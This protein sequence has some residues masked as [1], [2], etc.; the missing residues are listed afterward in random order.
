MDLNR[1]TQKAQQAIFA[2]GQ[3][4]SG[5]NHQLVGTKHL[6]AAL[7]DQEQGITGRFLQQAG[8]DTAAL[9]RDLQGLI[10]QIPQV[11]GYKGTMQ[12]DSTLA[13]VL[14][15]ERRPSSSRTIMSV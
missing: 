6:L 15:A 10:D 1:F 2:A 8:V 7:I 9:R 11:T 12:V 3:E 13:R 4:A 14:P 5:R